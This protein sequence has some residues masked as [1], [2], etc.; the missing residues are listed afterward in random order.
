MKKLLLLAS[1]GFPLLAR[2][3]GVLTPFIAYTT[4]LVGDVTTNTV[5]I[6]A[7]AQTN[8]ITGVST[9]LV[10]N[11]TRSYYPTNPAGFFSGYLAPG[12]YKLNVEGIDRGVVFGISA[13]AS[14]QNLAQ[15]AGIPVYAFQ[16]FTLA[17]FS[18]VGSIAYSNAST[19][20][21]LADL[22]SSIYQGSNNW[23]LHSDT[24]WRLDRITN[25]GTAGYSNAAAF[26]H[27]TDTNWPLAR[28]T[29]AGTAGYSNASAFVDTVNNQSAAGQKVWTGTN[30]FSGVFV[31]SNRAGVIHIGTISTTNLNG[32][33]GAISNGVW[34]NGYAS[35]L[36]QTG[37]A[38]YGNAFISQGSGSK[39]LQ[40]GEGADAS[41]G[42]STAIGN[43][44]V[45]SV[46]YA[47][48]IG[49]E[50]TA[51]AYAATAAGALANASADSATAIG[52]GATAA[53]TNSTA[54][55]KGATTTRANQTV[56]G[57]GTID[58]DIT[59]N[60]SVLG[61][62]SHIRATGTNSFSDL[63]LRRY[64]NTSLANGVNA[65]VLVGTNTF[66]QVS[67]PSAAFTIAGLNGSPN[68]DGQLA[69]VLNLTGYDMTVAH[70]SGGDPT[71]A[72]RI[73]TMTG[74]DRTTTGNGAAVFIY[75]TASS[76][77]INLSFDP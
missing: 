55:G 49:S 66:M 65:A 77:W 12:N 8:A 63:A 25:A 74:A 22:G 4:D 32:V 51:T 56:L 69:I 30:Y 48:A 72:N 61:N 10:L 2:S 47:S 39:S 20:A 73:Y 37:G 40:L 9:N 33:I 7:W 34:W 1:I 38:N 54:L 23:I 27:H 67:G 29:N 75:S 14:T 13:S 43:D 53:Y 36:T 58:V 44:S 45:A 24:N 19:Y 41:G 11:F 28:I 3:A 71:A 46:F 62:Q 21:R 31:V 35:S 6:Q 76:R 42:Q 26:L 18:D 50:A 60:F 5:T 52:K 15:L 57:S 59:G 17:Q 64:A 68:R 70:D 16:N